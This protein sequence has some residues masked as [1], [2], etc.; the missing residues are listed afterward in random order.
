MRTIAAHQE[1][2][3][4]KIRFNGM[5]IVL[6]WGGQRFPFNSCQSGWQAE[7]QSGRVSRA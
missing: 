7:S 3:S 5:D 2:D 4:G 1:P 6:P